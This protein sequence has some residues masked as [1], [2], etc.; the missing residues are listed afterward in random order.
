MNSKKI[1]KFEGILLRKVDNVEKIGEGTFGQVYKAIY[2]ND[3]GEAETI[4][5]KKFIYFEKD[6]QGLSM[7]TLR[8]MKYL[9]MLDHPNIVKL[10]QIIHSRPSKSES[11]KLKGSLYLIF[12]FLNFD[13]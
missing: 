8:E 2:T 7:T 13:L 11:N 3:K 6:N 1:S 10:R 9:K 12:D 5:I 4:A